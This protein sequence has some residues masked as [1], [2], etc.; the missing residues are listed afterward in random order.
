MPAPF[1]VAR[2][3]LVQPPR[4]LATR[5]LR[6]VLSGAFST[7]VYYAGVL[8]LVE[9]LHLDPVASAALA[10]A[11]VTATAYLVNR[12]WVF[13]SDR[14]HGSALPRFVAAS[15]LSMAI[16]AGLMHLVVHVIGGPYVAG[17]VLATLV[18]PPTNFLVNYWWCFREARPSAG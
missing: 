9:L 18:V 10:T 5:V 17:V 4:T 1:A 3:A 16:N 8:V 7:A 14:A 12:R 11:L 15:L 13:A 6:Y 2:A